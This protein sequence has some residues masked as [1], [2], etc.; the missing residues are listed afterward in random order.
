M[1][2]TTTRTTTNK[3]GHSPFASKR[4]QTSIRNA[5]PGPAF[6]VGRAAG[7][8][9]KSLSAESPRG[10]HMR[11]V[12]LT[13]LC[14]A[15]PALGAD[16][17]DP[18]ARN[19]AL[20]K[21]Y[22]E[23][24]RRGEHAQQAAM[25]APG[26]V[27]NG[28]PVTHRGDPVPARGHPSHLSRSPL[29]GPRDHR[30]RRHA[31]RADSAPRARI[32]ASPQTGIYGGMLRGARPGGKRFEVLRAHWWRFRDGKIVW[33]QVVSDDLAMMRQLGLVPD[34]LAADKLVAPLHKE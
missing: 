22:G 18:G 20:L 16:A 7:N 31:D 12:I 26:A 21:Q 6:S 29:R 11:L 32:V 14:L 17:A 9:R 13:L 1:R 33:H 30:E 34:T 25:W 3:W 27:N 15:V 10:E 23:L 5:G 4:G 28:S 24:G 8:P 2:M 19:L